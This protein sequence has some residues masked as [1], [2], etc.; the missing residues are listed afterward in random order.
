MSMLFLIFFEI[1]KL[2]TMVTVAFEITLKIQAFYGIEC[3]LQNVLYSFI[4]F[5][6]AFIFLR[7]DTF[8]VL[9]VLNA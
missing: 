1:K 2:K 8:E 3:Y 5:S 9:F 6:I 7:K 4:P